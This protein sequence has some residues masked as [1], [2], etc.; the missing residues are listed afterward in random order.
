[1]I[2]GMSIATFTIVHVVLSLI[3]IVTGIVAVLA[4]TGAR[5]LPGWTHAFLATTVLTSVTGYFFPVAKILPS[6]VVGAISLVLLA[7]AIVA[8]YRRRLEGKWRWIY[9]VTA[10]A[11]LYLN[12]FV[13]VVQ[14]F[15]KV[16]ALKALA[17]TQAEPPFVIAQGLVFAAFL[18]IGYLC[19]RRFHPQA[20]EPRLRTA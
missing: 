6:H 1:M 4:M 15:L 16:D 11:S 3:G 18:A 7:L 9:A 2:L 17:P 19:V 13:L 14:A 8:L 10:V 5:L 12:V 20:H